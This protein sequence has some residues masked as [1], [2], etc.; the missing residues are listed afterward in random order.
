MVKDDLFCFY[1]WVLFLV[2]AVIHLGVEI[3]K[4]SRT[5][6]VFGMTGVVDLQVFNA[7]LSGHVAGIAKIVLSGIGPAD[8]RGGN[9]LAACGHKDAV[10][11]DQFSLPGTAV[12]GAQVDKAPCAYGGVFYGQ[13]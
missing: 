9:R 7:D 2:A 13:Q 5:P 10:A 4:N 12:V 11:D 3:G 6:V 8:Q 1:I